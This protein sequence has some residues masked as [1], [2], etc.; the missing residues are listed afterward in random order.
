MSAP[1]CPKCGFTPKTTTGEYPQRALTQHSCEKQL[2]KAAARQR[3]LDREAAV[4]RTPQPC[5]H[6][7]AQHKHG[8][9]A[10]YVLDKCRCLPCAKANS[11]AELWRQRQKA[12]GR[13]DG[14]VD[15]DPV[16]EH[17]AACMAY[18]IGLKTVSKLSGVSTG[19]LS[20]I[21]YGT[22]APLQGK[23]RGRYGA[24]QLVRQ[25]SAG[26]T[27][28]TAERITSVAIVPANLP[29]RASDHERT[30][31]ARR[32]LRALVALGYSMSSLGRRLEISAA[33]INV[34]IAGDRPMARAT[35]DK[36]E[37]LYAELSMT[38]APATH[39]RQR[40]SV[41][42]AKR[43]A[44]E[45]GWLPPLDLEAL[46]D[47]AADELAGTVAEL[48]EL[49]EVAIERRL[50]G[51]KS[52]RLRKAEAAEAVA[53][54]RETGR[55]WADLARIAGINADRHPA[56]KRGTQTTDHSREDLAS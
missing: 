8:E 47:D 51:D 56:A 46:F 43:Y 55:T 33:N 3:R 41:N 45:R 19:V 17:L 23:S 39:Q 34:V 5:L 29:A 4:D 13:Y 6:K 35:V 44:R 24:G 18:G 7:V 38:P 32:Q 2:A 27:R 14:Y 22:Y 31:R 42:R 11:E 36:I 10:A 20:K 50:A 40:I 53:R 1:T 54:W 48:E 26:V 25:R 28:R 21:V 52:V 16:R 9:R 37:A 15:A 12:Y 49:D 30:P